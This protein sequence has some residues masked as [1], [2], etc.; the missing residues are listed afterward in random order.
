MKVPFIDLKRCEPDFN[1]EWLNQ[2]KKLTENSQ[3]IGG[4]PVSSLESELQKITESNHVI[5]CANGT[6]ALQLALRAIGVGSGD[7]VI[8]PDLTF[9]ATFEAVVNVGAKPYTLDCDNKDLNLDFNQVKDNI[10][11]INPKAIITAHLYGWGSKYLSDLRLLCKEK[12]IPLIEDSAQAFG[13]EYKNE[14]IFKDALI[15]TTSFYPAKVLGGAGD[16]GAVFVNDSALAN[17]VRCLSNHGRS[18]HYGYSDVGWNSRLDTL[19]A[20]YL[21]TTLPYLSQRIESRK[22][23]SGIYRSE[24]NSLTES[25]QVITPPIEYK[26]NGYLNVCI[27]QTATSKMHIQN[28]LKSNGIG[29]GNVY[30]SPLSTQKGA[31]G[32]IV[33]A[34]SNKNTQ[35]ICE[36]VLN[37]PLFPYM[38]D[39][40]IAY[41]INTV[42]ENI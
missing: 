34:G 27:F 39:E 19:Q 31:L 26:E 37:L 25:F 36:T 14:S 22:R 21:N 42:K 35:E 40:E 10:D 1:S 32:Y 17:K 5:T 29:F 41:V 30:P 16:G 38:R 4:E 8:V 12:G 20:A 2:V 24:L 28:A 9:W 11:L 23:I 6:D 15:A 13:V 7:I 3:F 18:E 33:G